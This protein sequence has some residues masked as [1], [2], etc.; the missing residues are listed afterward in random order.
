MTQPIFKHIHVTTNFVDMAQFQ[1]ILQFDTS[2]PIELHIFAVTCFVI[3]GGISNGL[4]IYLK[5]RNTNIQETYIY[6]TALAFVDIFSCAVLCPQYALMKAQINGFVNY[7]PFA[8]NQLMFS[9]I[10]VTFI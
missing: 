10:I 5:F 2:A 6:I 9:V 4:I 8:L 1:T 3:T 7:K